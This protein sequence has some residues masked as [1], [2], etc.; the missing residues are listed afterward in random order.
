MGGDSVRTEP[1]GT[2]TAQ[3]PASTQMA[4]VIVS[5]PG[6]ALKAFPIPVGTGAA[7]TLMLEEQGGDLHLVLPPRPAE[8]G[9][10]AI[11]L[12][13]FQNGLPL[14]TGVLTQWSIA[15][16]AY[17]PTDPS[18]GSETLKVPALAPGEY[19]ACL[20]AQ[21]VLVPWEASGWTAPLAKCA[22]GTLTAGGTLRL[23]LSQ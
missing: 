18:K 17:L 12:W 7:Q 14:S 5:A 13:V 22:A 6:H 8:E 19:R 2:F 20:A 11:A 3:I 4:D 23:D 9:K 21:G 10:D 15:Q 16:G 1:D